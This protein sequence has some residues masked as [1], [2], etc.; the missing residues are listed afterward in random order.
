MRVLLKLVLDCDAD[1][2]WRA[3]RSPSV[4][5][6]VSSPLLDFQSLE[7]DGFPELW[8]EGEHRVAVAGLGIVPVGEQVIAISYPRDRMGARLIRDSGYGLSGI[9]TVTTQWQHTMAVAP[10]PDGRTLYRDQLV[11]DAGYLSALLWPGYWLFWQWRA[12]RMRH[13]AR[14]W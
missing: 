5:K 11:F 7:A 3:I 10:L 1:V 6:E 12:L 13:L 14:T 8:P 2:A 4:L 9:F